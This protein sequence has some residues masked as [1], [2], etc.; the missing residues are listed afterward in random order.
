MLVFTQ[1]I[2]GCSVRVYWFVGSID[3][4]LYSKVNERGVSQLRTAV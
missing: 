3:L 4:V 1:D 2:V